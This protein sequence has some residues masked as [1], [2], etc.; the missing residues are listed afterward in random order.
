MVAFAGWKYAARST[1]VLVADGQHTITSFTLVSFFTEFFPFPPSGHFDNVVVSTHFRNRF[2]N[3][4]RGLS[5]AFTGRN[6][7]AQSAPSRQLLCA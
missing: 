6:L 3:S 1:P 5:K 4:R 7:G 2:S